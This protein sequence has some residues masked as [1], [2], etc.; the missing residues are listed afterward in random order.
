MWGVW[1]ARLMGMCESGGDG[2][3]DVVMVGSAI[4]GFGCWQEVLIVLVSP[5]LANRE[6]ERFCG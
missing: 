3:G 1:S 2:D 5:T 4:V 6:T